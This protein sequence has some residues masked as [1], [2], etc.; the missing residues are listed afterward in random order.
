MID[1]FD[2]EGMLDCL[3][4]GRDLGS[5]EGAGVVVA[6]GCCLWG[7]LDLDAPL[8]VNAE[9]VPEPLAVVVLLDVDA[10]LVEGDGCSTM[11]FLTDED[12]ESDLEDEE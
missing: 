4:K 8:A 6:A 12:L 7:D 3:G 9:G 10:V 2:A 1:R 11:T 5:K